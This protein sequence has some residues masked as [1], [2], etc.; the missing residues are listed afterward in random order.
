MIAT[1]GEQEIAIFE[2]WILSVRGRKIMWVRSFKKCEMRAHEVL[3]WER[4]GSEL[5]IKGNH[6]TC[7]NIIWLRPFLLVPRITPVDI[8]LNGCRLQLLYPHSPLDLIERLE[9]SYHQYSQFPTGGYSFWTKSNI[10][11]SSSFLKNI[12]ATL[13]LFFF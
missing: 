1:A 3:K 4:S 13:I 2:R 10:K 8:W 12:S 11:Y 7:R 9:Q 6:T 5:L